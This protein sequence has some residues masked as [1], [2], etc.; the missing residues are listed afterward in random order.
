MSLSMIE[1]W[2]N[3][4]TNSTHIADIRHWEQEEKSHQIAEYCFRGVLCH[5]MLFLVR[6]SHLQL[7]FKAHLMDGHSCNH[8]KNVVCA[9]RGKA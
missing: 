7:H 3:I 6:L 1:L 2:D 9:C 8:V 4:K 5:Q